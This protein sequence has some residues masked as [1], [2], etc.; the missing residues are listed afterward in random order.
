MKK[1][2]LW[3]ASGL[4]IL[5]SGVL[6]F[7][8]D[9]KEKN[10][11]IFIEKSSGNINSFLS[12]SQTQCDK[13]IE[14]IDSL[15]KKGEEIYNPSL[16]NKI[17]KTKDYLWDINVS[18]TV[19]YKIVSLENEIYAVRTTIDYRFRDRVFRIKPKDYALLKTLL[20]SLITK[21]INTIP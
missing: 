2:L 21:N 17:I 15:V 6:I 4:L 11:L 18:E 16:K 3:I 8:D 10:C 1:H 7:S 14:K 9:Q 5:I 12:L 19:E 13:L 20:N